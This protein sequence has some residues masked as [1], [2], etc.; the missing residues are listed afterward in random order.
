MAGISGQLEVAHSVSEVARELHGYARSGT[1][2]VVVSKYLGWLIDTCSRYR[3]EFQFASPRLKKHR[4]LTKDHSSILASLYTSRLIGRQD[5]LRRI[6]KAGACF[7]CGRTKGV[8]LDHYLPQDANLYPHLSYYIPN[9]VPACGSC[10]GTKGTFSPTL[11]HRHPIYEKG[12]PTRKRRAFL[13]SRRP[14]RKIFRPINTSR[15]IHPHFDRCIDP[16]KIS[17]EFSFDNAAGPHSPRL[18]LA[19]E[20]N[21]KPEDYLKVMFPN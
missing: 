20:E 10:Q 4:N 19:T 14:Q 18:F 16:S 15:L 1:H 12:S 13:A 2:A 7:Y 3:N 11:N 17:I 5:E 9:L 6:G 21:P 8:T